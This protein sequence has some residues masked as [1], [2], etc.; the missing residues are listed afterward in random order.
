MKQVVTR[1]EAINGPLVIVVRGGIF[2]FF[3]YNGNNLKG[4]I[5]LLI[6]HAC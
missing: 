5:C 6:N 2:F 1:N 3:L 4:S